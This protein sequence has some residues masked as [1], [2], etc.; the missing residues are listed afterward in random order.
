MPVKEMNYLLKM[1]IC[2]QFIFAAETWLAQGTDLCA[3]VNIKST[4]VSD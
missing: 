1:S 2:L 4:Q 3:M